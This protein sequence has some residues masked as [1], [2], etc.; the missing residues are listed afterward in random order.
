MLM[1]K[2]FFTA[3]KNLFPLLPF[4]LQQFSFL[5]FIIEPA[6]LKG[7]TFPVFITEPYFVHR[8]AVALF[9]SQKHHAKQKADQQYKKKFK[10]V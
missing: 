8:I 4:R 5:L 2:S 9:G 6:R 7:N 1:S 10:Y 3:P